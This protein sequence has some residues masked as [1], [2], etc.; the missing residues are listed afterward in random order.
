VK[1]HS[2]ISYYTKRV[3]SYSLFLLKPLIHLFERLLLSKHISPTRASKPAFIIGSPRTGSTI[4]YQALTNTYN[5]IYIDNLSCKWHRNLLFGLWLSYRKFNEIPHN[6]F[7][8]ENG[9]TSKYGDHAPSECG[10]FWYRW[11]PK[12]KHFIDHHEVSQAIVEKIRKEVKNVTH[13]F[14]RPMLFKNLNAGQRLRLLSKTFPQSKFIFIRRDPRFIVRSILKARIRARVKP[15]K[16]WSIMPPNYKELLGLPPL[17]MAAA[18]VFYLEKQINADLGL[19]ISENIREIHYRDLSPELIHSLG[20]W[21]GSKPRNRVVFPDFRKD[22][23]DQ[24]GHSELKDL[25]EAVAKY[26]FDKRCFE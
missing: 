24:L 5:I 19:F 12:E 2:H 8:A 4:L 11:L 1:K 23:L 17:E 14:D 7:L 18:Q 16:W 13:Y 9:D 20:K 26:P 3:E 10:N 21:I 22:N 25:D 6:N 15:G